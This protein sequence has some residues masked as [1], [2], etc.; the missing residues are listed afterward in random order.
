MWRVG[1]ASTVVSAGVHEDGYPVV[2]LEITSDLRPSEPM[3]VLLPL[4]D[5]ASLQA[6]I[7]RAR[8][9]AIEMARG[10]HQDAGS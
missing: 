5:V 4:R 7:D 6:G 8:L 1:N 2:V 10:A 9:E 3:V